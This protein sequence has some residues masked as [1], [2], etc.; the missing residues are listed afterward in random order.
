MVTRGSA[1]TE[2]IKLGLCLL[3]TLDIAILRI[4]RS[5]NLPRMCDG[6]SWSDE[7]DGSKL[8]NKYYKTKRLIREKIALQACKFKHDRR[9]VVA[10]K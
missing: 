1:T 8:I 4:H 2:L 5:S 7:G 3:L 10:T 9:K 6:L